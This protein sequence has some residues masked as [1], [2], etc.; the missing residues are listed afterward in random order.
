[1]SDVDVLTRH[2]L[3]QRGMSAGSPDTCSC[4]WRT[5]PASGEEN[6]TERRARA[7]AAHQAQVLADARRGQPT[8][9]KTM[10]DRCGFTSRDMGASW[11]DAFTYAVI[12]GWDAE[13]I[14]F[15]RDAHDRFRTLPDYNSTKD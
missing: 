5:F 15:L 3:Q 4:G 13:L 9:A 10:R 2:F 11:S 12:F 14:A 8:A 6:I 1:M 7:F